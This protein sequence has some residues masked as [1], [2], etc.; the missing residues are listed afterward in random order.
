LTLTT[1]G[2]IS[3]QSTISINFKI[4]LK[5]GANLGKFNLDLLDVKIIDANDF[6]TITDT[7]S[8][9]SAISQI[10]EK[11]T[12]LLVKSESK[13][14]VNVAKGDKNIHVLTLNFTNQGGTGTDEIN[15]GTITLSISDRFNNLIFA[16]KVLSKIILSYDG[17]QTIKADIPANS[18]IPINVIPPLKV[19]VDKSQVMKIKVDI[20]NIASVGNFK[21]SLI[22]VNAFD[23]WGNSV[24]IFG[25]FPMR[26]ESAIIFK[27]VLETSFTNYPNP[28]AAGRE[29]TTIA[30]YLPQDGYVTIKIYTVIGD[31]VI[32][33]LDNVFKSKGMHQEDTWDGRNGIGE[34]VLNGVYFCQIKVNYINGTSDKKVRKI[35]VVR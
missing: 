10:K 9:I 19:G 20:S 7:F 24:D 14:P 11:P 8:P 6:S 12:G 13:I 1:P 16:N 27:P 21:I 34:V 29:S 23:N 30:Y 18:N 2:V 25:E 26:S 28:F 17:T 15:I 32:T 33:L 35:A 31:L 4:D 22:E 3:P 5:I